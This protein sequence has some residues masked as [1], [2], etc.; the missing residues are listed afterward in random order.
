[1]R[2]YLTDTLKI[3][4]EDVRPFHPAN[5]GL[6]F[7]NRLFALEKEFKKQDLSPE[8]RCKARQEQSKPIA[9]KFFVWASEG[10]A[11]DLL[12][13]RSM[14]RIDAFIKEF[15]ELLDI[16]KKYFYKE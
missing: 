6:G 3:L 15:Y 1:M 10:M 16:M 12:I 5:K 11:S 9:D 2:R 13:N 8:E 4:E 7:C 14:D